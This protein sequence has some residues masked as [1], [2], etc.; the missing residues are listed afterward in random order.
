MATRAPF[1]GHSG[2]GWCRRCFA[3]IVVTLGLGVLCPTMLS[4][5]GKAL[6]I[7]QAKRGMLSSERWTPTPQLQTRLK[8]LEDAKGS[9]DP[10]TISAASKNALA[11]ALRDIGS[12]NLVH[13]SVPAAIDAYRRSLDFQNIT[14]TR[15]DLA[16]AY[17]RGQETDESLAI[18]TNILVADPE[19]VRAWFLQG[20]IWMAKM[21][22]DEA[23]RS[24][25]KVLSLKEDSAASYLLG[26]ALLQ[27]KDYDGA[28][29]AFRSAH[30]RNAS[31]TTLH[32]SLADAYLAAGYMKDYR[33]ESAAALPKSKDATESSGITRV[34]K[35]A[36]YFDSS[37]GLP[38]RTAQ[39]RAKAKVDERELRSILASTLNDLAVAEAQQQK[40]SMALAHFHE[41]ASWNPDLSGLL[42]NTGIAAARAED[43]EECIRALR[44]VLAGQPDD[45]VVRS[46]LGTALFATHAYAEATQVFSPL[47]DSA[48]QLHELAY[49]WAASLVHINKYAD[50]TAL[51]D[52]LEQR[53]LSPDTSIL[54]AQLWSQ[55]GSYAKAVDNC[56]RALQQDPKLPRAHYL[57]GLALLHLE[58]AAEAEQ[59][60]QAELQLNPND[61]DAK[62][63]LAFSLLQ[64]SKNSVAVGLLKEVVAQNPD[65]AEANYE[66]G[67][68]LVTEGKSEDAMAYLEAAVRLK[69]DFEPAHY[70]LQSAYRALGRREDADREASI[71]RALKAKS[72]N[73]TLPPPRQP[74]SGSPN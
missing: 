27:V 4:Q 56:H 38:P 70:Q 25:R 23:A 46:M 28:Q 50:A 3:L 29:I 30:P 44:P 59:D 5:T 51:L 15:L 42:R 13:D 39:D 20:K 69:P 67:K 34:I 26:A 37:F 48:L 58:R 41:A 17:F 62:F 6:A 64:Q 60:F 1:F 14:D 8:A 65:H 61:T 10:D 49:S 57:A 19:N 11:T 53:K 68:E 43:Y 71:Y 52:K 47:G 73:I 35:D 9:G 55:M 22:Y 31:K 45:T 2:A 36:A 54:I 18:A 63:H 74:S 33:R 32:Q 7:S 12:T 24:F 21:R 40:Y 16:Q 72:R 66:L